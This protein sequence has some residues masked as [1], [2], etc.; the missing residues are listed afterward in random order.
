MVRGFPSVQ[1][2]WRESQPAGAFARRS[3]AVAR[4]YV[5][6]LKV[7]AS[8]RKTE[9]QFAIRTGASRGTSTFSDTWPA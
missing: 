4:V 8:T 3:R 7:S 1:T 6:Y 2:G 5:R 9:M